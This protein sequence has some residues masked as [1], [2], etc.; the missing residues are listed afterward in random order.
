[1]ESIM[2]EEDKPTAEMTILEEVQDLFHFLHSLWGILAG[3]TLFFP[4]SAAFFSLI[5]VEYRWQT[6]DYMRGFG[7][8]KPLLVVGLTTILIIFAMFWLVS[9]REQFWPR[10]RKIM[11]QRALRCPQHPPHHPALSPAPTCSPFPSST[12]PKPSANCWL[13]TGRARRHLARAR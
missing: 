1:M 4:L 6:D 7:Y 11:Q 13:P 9:H 5:P 12:N 3:V 2:D 10:K 8:F